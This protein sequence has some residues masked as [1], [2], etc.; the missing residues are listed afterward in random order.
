M[1]VAYNMGE[2]REIPELWKVGWTDRPSG[3]PRSP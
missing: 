3:W 2:W 1:V